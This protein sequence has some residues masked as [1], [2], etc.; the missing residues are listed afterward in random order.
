MRRRRGVAIAAAALCAALAAC[1]SLAPKYEQPPLPVAERFSG[2]A[3]T[4]ARGSPVSDLDWRQ[5]FV[6][7]LQQRLIDL[8]LANNRDLRVAALNVEQANARVQV[9]RASLLPTVAAGASFTRQPLPGGNRQQIVSAGVLIPSYELDF[10]GRLRSLTEAAQAQAAAAEEGRRTTQMSLI[11]A[12]AANHLALLADDELLT[13]TQET[14]ATRVE[15]LRLIK[16][17]FDSGTASELDYQ[18]AQSLVANAR[19]SLAQQQRQRALDEN[20]L[21]LLLGQPLPQERSQAGE[22]RRPPPEG[23]ES[24]GKAASTRDLP[25]GAPTLARLPTFPDLPVGL[26]AEVLRRRPDIRAAEQQLIAA[27]FNIGAARAAFFPSVT[28]TAS[29]GSVSSELS[30]LFKSGN[31]AWG[32]APQIVQTLFDSG[33][34]SANTRI[35]ETGRDIALA[36][37][38]KAIQSA[39]REVADA[40]AGRTTLVEQARALQD[41]AAADAARLR[42]AELR[43]RNGV[44]SSLDLLDAQR[45]LFAT[46]QL[47]VLAQ[48]AQAQNQVSL[49]K[50]LGGGWSDGATAKEP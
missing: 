18:G 3:E 13:L 30:G 5:V 46:Q 36:Q 21:V 22:M 24:S 42:L 40:L 25:S 47:S 23:V 49:Y 38:D 44:A 48:L 20:N 7:P 2:A 16:L 34:N 26:P 28:L 29:A 15:T 17:R 10:F 9:Q 12:V 32:V 39:F 27:N 50:A 11:A 45:S 31:W 8:A 43:Y 35:A 4:P 19:A 14:L 37:Y 33:R 6:D 41:Q 1:T